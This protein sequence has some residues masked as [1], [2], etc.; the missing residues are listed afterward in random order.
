VMDAPLGR[1]GDA[2]QMI[3]NFLLLCFK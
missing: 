3:L 1:W 2:P